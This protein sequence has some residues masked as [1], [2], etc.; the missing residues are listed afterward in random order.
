MAQKIY[1]KAGVQAAIV[2]AVITGIF[3]IFINIFINLMQNNT[4]RLEEDIK[5]K[6]LKIQ[7]LET[8]LIPFKTIALEKFTGTENER[9]QQ[10]A[11]NL[12]EIVKN[13]EEQ[14]WKNAAQFN[15]LCGKG[16]VTATDPVVVLMI[17]SEKQDEQNNPVIQ[18]DELHLRNW[19]EVISMEPT[20]PFPYYYLSQCYKAKGIA[21][22][23]QYLAEMRKIL[24]ETIKIKGRHPAHD[25][26]LKRLDINL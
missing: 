15:K 1:E 10:L 16:F 6:D 3:L 5:A 24:D 9:L 20:C 8:Q 11:A 4:K 19:N 26:I 21:G 12:E 13:Q 14:K 2:G 23:E 18:C 22:W 17:A 7:Q 25:E